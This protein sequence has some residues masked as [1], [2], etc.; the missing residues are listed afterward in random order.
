MV[1]DVILVK[2]ILAKLNY[3]DGMSRPRCKG[4]QAIKYFILRIRKSASKM[5]RRTTKSRHRDCDLQS[6]G[7][8][9]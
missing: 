2:V 6:G 7:D 1:L 8:A 9:R 3:Q 5:L 4:L